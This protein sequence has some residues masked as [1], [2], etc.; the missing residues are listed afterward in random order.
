MLF[1]IEYIGQIIGCQLKMQMMG[2]DF[3]LGKSTEHLYV[4]W[5]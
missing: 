2:P 5:L 1:E 3:V 4:K